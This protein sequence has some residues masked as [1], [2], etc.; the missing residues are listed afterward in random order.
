MTYGSDIGGVS[1]MKVGC[2]NLDM[3][4]ICFPK[5][6]YIRLIEWKIT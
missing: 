6:A 1:F 4:R 3:T 2:E 5:G